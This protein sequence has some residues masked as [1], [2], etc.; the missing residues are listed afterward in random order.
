MPGGDSAIGRADAKGELITPGTDDEWTGVEGSDIGRRLG[1]SRQLVN[2]RTHSPGK[3]CNEPGVS[4][5]SE[6]GTRI[7]F[8]GVVGL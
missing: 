7:K 8:D 2:S 1:V 6:T 5:E 3:A 4:T